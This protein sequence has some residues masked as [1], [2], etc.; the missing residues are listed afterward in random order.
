MICNTMMKML[1]NT[2]IIFLRDILKLTEIKGV[3]FTMTFPLDIIV[4]SK[5][6]ANKMQKILT[7]VNKILFLNKKSRYLTLA[8][9][10]PS[11]NFPG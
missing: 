5:Y 2:N 9:L 7:Q 3:I 8:A 6:K 1:N 10:I 4:H 11:F